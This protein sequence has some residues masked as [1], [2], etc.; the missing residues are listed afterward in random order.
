MDTIPAG[1]IAA[2]GYDSPAAHS[3]DDQGLAFET[4]IP[5]AFNGH[6]EGVQVQ[7]EYCPVIHKTKYRAFIDVFLV[8]SD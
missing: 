6:E 7:V 4:A 3:P 5:Q 1:F 2:G 8:I